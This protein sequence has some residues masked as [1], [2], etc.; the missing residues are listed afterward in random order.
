MLKLIC[1]RRSV[2][3]VEYAIIAGIIIAALAASA[4]DVGRSLNDL[5]SQVNTAFP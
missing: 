4:P 1:D 2:T 5:I 3:A